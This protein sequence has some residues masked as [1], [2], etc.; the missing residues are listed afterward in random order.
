MC[1]SVFKIELKIFEK[2]QIKLE[3]NEIIKYIYH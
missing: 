1:L 3:Y 2:I